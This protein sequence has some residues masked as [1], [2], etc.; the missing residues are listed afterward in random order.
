M[1]AITVIL[2]SVVA[3]F[4]FGFTGFASKGPT[5]GIVVSNIRDT[6]IYDIQILHKGGDNL[7]ANE[8]RISIVKVGDPPVYVIGGT[9]FRPG[10]AII[11]TNLTNS[12]TVTVT[13]SSITVVPS[14][15]GFVLETKYDI[16]I[17]MYP[18]K[19]LVTDTI[20]LV[21]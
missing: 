2:A 19:T 11:T 16:K 12:G 15:P 7:K 14:A 21:R 5:A 13:N 6:G 4:G 18:Y 3:V 17:I 9:D 10:D 20:I 1:V 8:W